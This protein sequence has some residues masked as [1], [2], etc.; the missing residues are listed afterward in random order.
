[1]ITDLAL[2]RT[3]IGNAP[4][5]AG[6]SLPGR[7]LTCLGYTPDRVEPPTFYPG[8][9]TMDRTASGQRTFG[10]LRGYRV[11]A[12]VL[13]S[14]AEDKSGQEALD[15]LLSEGGDYDLIGAIE[16]DKTLGGLCNDLIVESVDGYR[17]YTVGQY[18]YYGAR[19][20]ILVLG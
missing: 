17:L 5:V 3:R 16:A 4:K 12:T 19:F 15:L 8:E 2:L 6:V 14:S 11:T 10:N 1:M 18:V 13:T 9:I 7:G 20:T